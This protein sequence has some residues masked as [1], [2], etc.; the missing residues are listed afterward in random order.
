MRR[1]FLARG[2]LAAASFALALGTFAGGGVPAFGAP[3]RA[4]VPDVVGLGEPE[5]RTLL[6][7]VGFAVEVTEA[8]GDLAG[9][10]GTVASQSPGG[11]ATSERGA[12]VTIAVRRGAASRP[13]GGAGT[14]AGASP[15]VPSVIGLDEDAAMQ[16][17][18]SAGL[19][20]LTSSVQ[21]DQPTW[22][23]R[24][25]SQEPAGLTPVARSSNVSLVVGR[26]PAGM[27]R[28]SEV[29]DLVRLSEADARARAAA[30]GFPVVVRDRL[31]GDT[32]GVGLV[33][34]QEPAGGS[35]L[36]RGR[37]L[38]LVV[39]RLLLLPIR[40]P[41]T[42]GLD[43]ALAETTLRD[44]GFA[45]ETQVAASPVGSTGK[46]LS[47]E[48][49]GGAMAYRGSTVRITVGR[50]L[51]PASTSVPVPA[52]V[53]RTEAEARAD[54]AAAGLVAR[55]RAA[56]PAPGV[57]P[58]RVRGQDPVAGAFVARGSEVAIDVATAAPAATRRVLIPNY[59]GVD[60]PT[61]QAGLEAL[62]L[63]VTVAYAAGTPDGVV[64][65][66]APPPSTEV[67]VGSVVTIRVARAPSLAQVILT[68]P[69]D[70]TALPRNFGVTFTWN[71]VPGAED[72][73][74]QIMENKNGE[75]K[76]ADD[77]ILRVP[78]KRPA[79]VHAGW[80]Q[81]H[82]RARGQGGAVSGPWSEWRR[83]QIY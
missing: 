76:V 69:A 73:Q 12:R 54:L 47:Q 18:S 70:R 5:A 71:P 38:H 57:A 77:D 80:Y 42:T 79:R 81:W 23:G 64:L 3:E 7:L 72:Y 41:E 22:N 56:D 31:A 45:V 14:P 43:A 32:G 59:T 11:F 33:L 20:P 8:T 19:V 67:A 1:T 37:T 55:V 4:T 66:Q 9:A 30:A 50:S 27:L 26:A 2:L 10:P 16:R 58:G 13:A 17:I 61:A 35:R 63:R 83:L 34:E 78:T 21:V 51:V 25:V 44:A 36:L 48:P 74:F 49:A 65:D 28:E 60:G 75:W 15:L 40:L 24:V 53:G 52:V 62:G 68:G 6:T 46:V 39:G 82:V 29:P